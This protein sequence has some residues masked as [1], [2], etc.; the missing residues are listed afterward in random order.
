M[1]QVGVDSLS[2]TSLILSPTLEFR[3]IWEWW[4]LSQWLGKKSVEF[5]QRE[6]NLWPQAAGQGA[7]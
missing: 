2:I 5:S 6:S 4:F 3:N 1:L 7:V